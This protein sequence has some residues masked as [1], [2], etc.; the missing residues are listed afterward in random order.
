LLIFFE[1]YNIITKLYNYAGVVT[2]IDNT[3]HL[4]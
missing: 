3:K 4:Y 2:Y 1:L